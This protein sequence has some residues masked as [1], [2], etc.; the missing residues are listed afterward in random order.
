MLP[1]DVFRYY[2]VIAVQYCSFVGG[3]IM[4]VMFYFVAI[5]ITV[6]NE[7]PPDK[8]GVQLLYFAPGMV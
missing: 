3:M 6:V 1:L 2:D 4:L 8:A 7:L 5:F